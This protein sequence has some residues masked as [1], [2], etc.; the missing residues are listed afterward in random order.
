MYFGVEFFRLYLDVPCRRRM[1]IVRTCL[2]FDIV[3][4]ALASAAVPAI[5]ERIQYKYTR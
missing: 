5:A 2:Q 1:C 4:F 3:V